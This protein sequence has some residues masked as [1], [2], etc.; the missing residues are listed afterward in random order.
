MRKKIDDFITVDIKD[1]VLELYITIKVPDYDSL[2]NLR[3]LSKIEC[4][5][6][7]DLV[8]KFASILRKQYNK[9]VKVE[10]KNQTLF[11]IVLK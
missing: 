4:D 7:E 3:E 5:D 10:E 8:Y 9:Q 6:N 1:P 11:T 2:P